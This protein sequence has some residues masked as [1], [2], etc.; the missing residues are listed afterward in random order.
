MGH[1][2]QRT[3][4][5]CRE[6]TGPDRLVRLTVVD[7]RGPVVVPDPRRRLGGRGAWL[8]PRRDCV[9]TAIRRRA[10]NRA[11]RGAVRLEDDAELLR[12]ILEGHGEH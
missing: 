6:V 5:G 10:F 7:D 3:C 1:V 9:D 2:P 11:F 12:R 4:I 8:H